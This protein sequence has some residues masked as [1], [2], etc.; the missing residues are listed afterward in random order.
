MCNQ[1][2]HQRFQ[3]FGDKHTNHYGKLRQQVHRA[4]ARGDYQYAAIAS[5][6]L[7]TN[8][9]DAFIEY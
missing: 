2:S 9:D 6:L 8:Y 3:P 4:I 7:H 1:E 5:Q